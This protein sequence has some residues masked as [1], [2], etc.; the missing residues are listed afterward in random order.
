M[1]VARRPAHQPATLF[2]CLLYIGFSLQGIVVWRRRN[3]INHPQKKM[4]NDIFCIFHSDAQHQLMTP[5]PCITASFASAQKCLQ[6]PRR[7]W[8]VPL[9]RCRQLSRPSMTP[10]LLLLLLP[11][12]PHPLPTHKSARGPT[13]TSFLCLS[14]SK[15]VVALVFKLEF[16]FVVCASK[17]LFKHA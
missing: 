15:M 17:F 14:V 9:H 3:N 1:C 13:F 7:E 10:L 5:D 12:L 6:V 2:P 8:S 16:F 4:S 11:P